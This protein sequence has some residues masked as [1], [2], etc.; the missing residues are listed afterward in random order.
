MKILF[1]IAILAGEAPALAANP[2]ACPA[3]C[4]VERDE[5]LARVPGDRLAG[6]QCGSA[7]NDCIAH[8]AQ[9]NSSDADGES[10]L[11]ALAGE[12]QQ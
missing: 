1:V 9:M 8:C 2:Y 5:C 12:A 11:N 7:F 3:A 6:D 10:E 4:E